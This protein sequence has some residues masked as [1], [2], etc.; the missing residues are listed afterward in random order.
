MHNN[1]KLDEQEITN[2]I[3]RH[4][5]LIEKEKQ[6]KLIIN[7]TK[8]KTSNLIVENNTSSAKIPLNQT[9]LVYKFYV[10]FESASRKTNNSYIG[11]TITT[12]FRRLTYHLS[13]NNT[14]KQ[15]LTIVLTNLHLPM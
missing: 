4:I 15:H 7:Y 12:L 1:Y 2:I 8:F 13:E 3:K 14:I 5:K 11:Y 10:H 6:L 9:N